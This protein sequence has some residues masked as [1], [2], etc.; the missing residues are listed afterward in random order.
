MNTRYREA[1]IIPYDA[2]NWEAEMA[3]EGF[4]TFLE[5]LPELTEQLIEAGLVKE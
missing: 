2:L 5:A 1:D 3:L 4:N